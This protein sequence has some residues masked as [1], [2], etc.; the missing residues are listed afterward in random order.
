M[1]WFSF[2]VLSIGPQWTGIVY[3]KPWH[4]SEKI[5]VCRELSFPVALI[6]FDNIAGDMIPLKTTITY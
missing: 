2:H 4:T 3:T 6:E 1:L 5:E